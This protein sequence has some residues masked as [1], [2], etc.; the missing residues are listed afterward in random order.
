MSATSGATITA[1]MRRQ[2]A[3]ELRRSGASYGQIAADLGMARSAVHETVC[4]ALAALQA[5]LDGQARLL[6]AQEADRLDR[7]QMALW[8]AATDGDPAAVT[9]VLRI[10]ERRAKLL[11]L[12]QT[13]DD[14]AWQMPVINVMLTQDAQDAGSHYATRQDKDLCI[15]IQPGPDGPALQ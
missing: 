2:R 1:R 8:P 12:D 3:V 4:R 14:A 13:A 5:D 10:M 7:L 6:Q 9:A 11:G 15:S